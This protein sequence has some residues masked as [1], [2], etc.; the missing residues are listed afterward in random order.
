MHK[1]ARKVDKQWKDEERMKKR[2]R[3]LQLRE[4]AAQIADGMELD[5]D[6]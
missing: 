6:E 4:E 5:V 2:H 3:A 1:R